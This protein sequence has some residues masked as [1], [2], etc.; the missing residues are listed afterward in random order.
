MRRIPGSILLCFLLVAAVSEARAQKMYLLV[1]T[2]T[3][4]GTSA[5]NPTMDSSG[6]KGI[7]VYRFDEATGRAKLLSH[8]EGVCN[9]SYLAVAPDGHHVYACTESRM[10]GMGS[11]SAFDLDHSTG[12]LRFINKVPSGG[13]NP[14]YVS[15]DS[16]GRW[17][18]VANYTGGSFSLCRVGA[19]G[20]LS[21]WVQ[22]L[23]FSG[24]GVNP[25]RQERSHVHSAVFSPD[26]RHLYVQD[27]GLDRISMYPFDAGVGA[28]A[29]AGAREEASASGGAR[30]E[31]GASAGAAL[32][33]DTAAVKRFSVTPGAGPRHLTFGPD[34]R[35][36]YLVE[37]MGGMVDVYH[38]D[39]V[40]G[41]LDPLQ[42]IAAHPD[43][44]S[45]SWRSSDVHLSPDGEFLY[46]SN[47]AE[48]SITIFSVDK[49]EGTLRRIGFE[50]VFG[51]E[52][53]NFTIDPTGSWLL[54]GDQD[55]NCI[56]VYRID[57]TTGDLKPLRRRIPVPLPTYLRVIP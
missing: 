1:G 27:L 25:Q 28:G 30:T 53:R 38:Y 31:A 54:V 52:P 45:G 3:N 57:K 12:R 24:H 44:A 8:T 23:A 48:T 13:D 50:S 4:T 26:M 6:S 39:P 16:S 43:T 15:V 7:Y 42:R 29:D 36:A 2:Y 47:R 22:R 41:V 17:V 46:A 11:V 18:V 55:S 14:A 20:G 32:P 5:T 56:V 9:P 21:P 34:G 35:F 19:D 33:L 10:V 49:E 40:T 37:E 51:R